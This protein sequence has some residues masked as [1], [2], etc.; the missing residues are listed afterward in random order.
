MFYENI[1]HE[2]RRDTKEKTGENFVI[3]QKAITDKRI[4]GRAEAG[5]KGGKSVVG[6]ENFLPKSST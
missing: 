6:G 2:E 1:Y 4:N 5:K 3:K